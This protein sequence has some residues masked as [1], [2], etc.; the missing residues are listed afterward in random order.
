VGRLRTPAEGT[1]IAAWALRRSLFGAALRLG[2][3]AGRAYRPTISLDATSA[4]GAVRGGVHPSNPADDSSPSR[5]ARPGLVGPRPRGH[6]QQRL[7]RRCG[8]VPQRTTSVTEACPPDPDLHPIRLGLVAARPARHQDCPLN[9]AQIAGQY[10][11][12]APSFR[13]YCAPRQKSSL[14]CPRR[15]EG[16]DHQLQR[17]RGR[18]LASFNATTWLSAQP[19]SAQR[20]R[21]GTVQGF[22]SSCRGCGPSS[23]GRGTDIGKP[24][25]QLRCDRRGRVP[26]SA[27]ANSIMTCGRCS[28]LPRQPS[29]T[30][31]SS[32]LAGIGMN[33]GVVPD[34][35]AHIEET[36]LHAAEI[37]WTTGSA[38]TRHSH[39]L[40]WGN[41]SERI[42]GW[43]AC[44]LV[45]RD[46][47]WT[48]CWWEP[49]Q[50]YP[51]H[52]A[53]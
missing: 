37:G 51:L 5:V 33:L 2:P 39:D 45:A 43:P 52:G 24:D 8:A 1:R 30:E 53:V 36:L 35:E 6:A 44:T 19:R 14:A 21:C 23:R 48:C 3:S 42:D 32:R 47:R 50:M 26:A 18:E 25:P 12:G 31:L 34:A 38:D 49:I 28:A 4:R 7:H 41:G 10:R 29:P 9:A 15:S 17:C 40:A 22:A 46:L 16:G 11:R 27:T 13:S 20:T